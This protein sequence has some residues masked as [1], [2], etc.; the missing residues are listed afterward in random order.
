M[1]VEAIK[2]AISELPPDDQLA[3]ASWLNTQT[4]D[5]WDREMARDFTPGGRGYHVVERVKADI[6]AG[7][8]RPMSEGRPHPPE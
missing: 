3:L 7:K 4:M 1:T 5:E 2:E 6:R 8:S